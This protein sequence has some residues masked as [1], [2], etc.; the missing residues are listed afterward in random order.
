VS[1]RTPGFDL[2]KSAIATLFI[3]VS[4]KNNSLS[5]GCLLIDSNP[6]CDISMPPEKTAEQVQPPVRPTIED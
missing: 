4:N 6:L 5:A 2:K 3:R 1:S